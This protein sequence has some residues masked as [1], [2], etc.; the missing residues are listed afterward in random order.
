MLEDRDVEAAVVQPRFWRDGH[1]A[2]VYGPFATVTARA[3]VVTV[4]LVQLDPHPGRPVPERD[5]DRP[6]DR[7]PVAGLESLDLPE[8]RGIHPDGTRLEERPIATCPTSIF[9]Q[10]PH[11][12][13]RRSAR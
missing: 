10:T 6:R 9:G 4:L 8:D 11:A 2:P 1:P 3:R 7:R 5:P 12:S 13:D